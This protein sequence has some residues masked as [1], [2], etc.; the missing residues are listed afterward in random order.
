MKDGTQGRLS[1]GVT[2]DNEILHE[3][4]D[5]FEKSSTLLQETDIDFCQRAKEMA[6]K[7]AGGKDL[8]CLQPQR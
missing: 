4:F 6:E 1:Y 5:H 7:M 2:M 3:L 8:C